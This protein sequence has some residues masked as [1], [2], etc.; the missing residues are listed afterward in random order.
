MSHSRKRWKLLKFAF[1]I[2]SPGGQRL[3]RGQANF[4]RKEGELH[5][6]RAEA[7]DPCTKQANC[8]TL[9]A[10][11]RGMSTSRRVRTSG[12]DISRNSAVPARKGNGWVGVNQNSISNP[13]TA[14]KKVLNKS[15]KSEQFSIIAPTPERWSHHSLNR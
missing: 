9:A 8:H 13:G 2:I 11:F 7:N 4:L 3:P 12:Y 14:T 10:P 5:K 6:R 15:G 1:Q